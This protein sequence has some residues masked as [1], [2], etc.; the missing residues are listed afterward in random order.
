M[1]GPARAARQVDMRVAWGLCPHDSA[2]DF[3]GASIHCQSDVGAG[4]APTHHVL[5]IAVVQV[6]HS[7]SE[8]R[9]TQCTGWLGLPGRF[10]S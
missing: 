3:S 9:A 10:G 8:L 4:D 6:W 2:L 1:S 5:D 7:V